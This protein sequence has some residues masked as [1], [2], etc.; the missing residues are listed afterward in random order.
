[1]GEREGVSRDDIPDV[2][3]IK[4]AALKALASGRQRSFESLERE[5]AKM[6]G[7]TSRQERYCISGSTTPLFANRVEKARAELRKDGLVEY[8][9]AGKLKLSEAGKALIAS[10]ASEEAEPPQV[11]RRNPEPEAQLYEPPRSATPEEEKA[12]TPAEGGVVVFPEPQKKA[13][14]PN[15]PLILAIVGLV[16]CFT[17]VLAFA[18]VLCGLASLGLV[19]FGKKRAGGSSSQARP[20][21]TLVVAACAVVLGLVMSAGAAAGGNQAPPQEAPDPPAARQEAAPAEQGQLSF[22]V[23]GSGDALPASVTV[24]V[25][26]AQDDGTKVDDKHEA[27]LGKSYVLAYPAGTYTFTVDPSSLEV[28]ES[29]FASD[30]VKCSFDGKKDQAARISLK[31]DAA[32]MAKIE[33]EKE[34]E[35]Q[36]AEA[37]AAAKAAEEEAAAQKAAEEEAAAAAAAEQEAAA[38]AAAAAAASGGGGSGDVTVYI[39]KT[40]EKFHRDG[41]QYLRKSQIP[42]SRSNAIAQGYG[43]CSR[44]NP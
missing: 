8:P 14:S 5:A 38:A 37:E 6:L 7:L 20:T 2:E 35:R 9:N 41:C 19:Y 27:A 4:E 32:S 33:A 44:C 10:A 28:G 22:V 42:I 3:V 23:N 25:T 30:P 34:A 18:G 17:G 31:L 43:A 12:A 15:L 16:L 26:G 39:T 36:K 40:G 21:A 13:A 1:M 11:E 24:L 29:V